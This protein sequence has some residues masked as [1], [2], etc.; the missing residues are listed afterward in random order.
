MQL[1]PRSHREITAEPEITSHSPATLVFC[2][3]FYF[4]VYFLPSKTWLSYKRQWQNAGNLTSF[5]GTALHTYAGPPASIS[6]ACSPEI[7]SSSGKDLKIYCS[8]VAELGPS[9]PLPFPAHTH[10]C[11]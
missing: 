9:L 7:I 2:F 10:A 8:G 3:Q 11:E 6:I 5:H 4:L 1:T